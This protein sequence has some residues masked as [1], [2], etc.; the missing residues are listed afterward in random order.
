V[1][2]RPEWPHTANAEPRHATRIGANRA[3]SRW[4]FSKRWKNL[5]DR[6]IIQDFFQQQTNGSSIQMPNLDT[7]AQP[8]SLD[9][10]S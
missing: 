5:H 1:Q 7:D 6:T 9:F 10:I 4:E 8:P 3:A 2:V